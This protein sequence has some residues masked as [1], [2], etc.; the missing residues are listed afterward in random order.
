V[1][2]HGARVARHAH[3]VRGCATSG[4]DEEKTRPVQAGVEATKTGGDEEKT[5][6]AQAFGGA[7][8]TGGEQKARPAQ[9]SGSARTSLGHGVVPLQGARID[10]ASL[11]KRV[12][13]AGCARLSMGRPAPNR[14]RRPRALRRD[15]DPRASGAAHGAASA[16]TGAGPSPE[17]VRVRGGATAAEGAFAG[18]TRRGAGEGAPKHGCRRGTRVRPGAMRRAQGARR[19]RGP[20]TGRG[21]SGLAP[22][23]PLGK[24][25][26]HAGG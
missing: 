2:P 16:P 4:G 20:A 25:R 1:V 11:L 6:P 21:R 12:F 13:L 7:A 19:A 15:R 26:D 10:W 23:M 8:K 9:G 18:A 22:L 3:A 14:E 5:R 17:G 24:R